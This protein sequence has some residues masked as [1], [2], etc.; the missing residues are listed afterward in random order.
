MCRHQMERRK[1]VV[2]V[3][4]VDLPILIISL[5]FDATI[6]YAIAPYGSLLD[7]GRGLFSII[8]CTHNKKILHF[9]RTDEHFCTFFV[10]EAMI[11][12]AQRSFIAATA[13]SSNL[14]SYIRHI[15]RLN[16]DFYLKKYKKKTV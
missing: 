3:V 12:S 15:A 8:S 10:V 2:V 11:T 14:P 5:R 9:C 13:E 7:L 6:S 1:N 4:V 16:I